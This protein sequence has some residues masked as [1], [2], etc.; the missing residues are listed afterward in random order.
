MGLQIRTACEIKTGLFRCKAEAVAYCQYC[1]RPFCRQHGTVV[2]DQEVCA[3]KFCV[4][5][6]ED[7]VKHLAYKAVVDRRNE[8]QLCGLDSCDR[9]T[10]GQCVR[11]KGHFCSLHV[12]PREEPILHNKVTVTQMATL[13][14]HCW[15]RR[16]IWVRM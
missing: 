15:E 4:A 8:A 13:C 12:Q 9:G 10:H 14:Y 3:R 2:G 16:S 11:C 6:R 7:L 5:K 1:G